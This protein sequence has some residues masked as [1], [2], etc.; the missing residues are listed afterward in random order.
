MTKTVSGVTSSPGE[1]HAVFF[2]QGTWLV[3]ATAVSGVFMLAT[4]IVAQNGMQSREYLLFFTLLRVYLL[5]GIPAIGLQTVFTQQ[6]ASAVGAT[7]E[8]TLAATVHAV[9]RG[10]LV[11]WM[12]AA[13][14]TFAAQSWLV[15]TLGISNPA[16][17]W[18]TLGMGL[19]CLWGPV[20]RGVVQGRQ[21][22]LGLGASM[23]MD[24]A[25]RFVLVT[26]ILL[27]G[28]QAAGAM[29]G[30]L[31]GLVGSIA[32]CAWLVR[33]VLRGR[34]TGFA[35]RGWLGRVVPL[36]FGAGTIQLLTTADVIYVK[37]VFPEADWAL[38]IPAAMVGLAFMTFATPLAQVMFPKVARSAALTQKSMALPLA[39]AATVG[40]GALGAIACSVVPELPLR[41]IYFS[42]PAFWVAA[43]LVPWFAWAVLPLTVAH[44]LINGL[45][46]RERYRVVPWVAA[47]GVIYLGL[48]YAGR[49]WLTAQEPL[50]AFRVLLGTLG[51]CNT[52][53]LALAVRFTLREPG[54]TNSWT[55]S[56]SPS[57]EKET[58]N[59]KGQGRSPAEPQPSIR[60]TRPPR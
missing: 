44:I 30:A 19:A 8:A 11:L 34:A 24:G 36:T 28:G 6:T 40:G 39:L 27:W 37:S 23:L 57:P 29:T 50:M 7:R 14:G 54:V 53:V 18:A 55:L 22:F 16:A 20:F 10:T 13:V 31:L 25:G 38:Y 2:R 60:L 15:R 56:D 1:G 9:L 35:W 52:A 41:L 58:Q 48:L 3:F 21:H 5:L 12:C 32:L 49:G 4:Q 17:L 47:M 59:L 45:L 33:D 43:P 42:K 46:A 26:V 51:A